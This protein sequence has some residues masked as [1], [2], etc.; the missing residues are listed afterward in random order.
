MKNHSQIKSLVVG[1]LLTGVA[2]VGIGA[3]GGDKDRTSWEYKIFIHSS[4]KIPSGVETKLTE[5]GSL[6]W[7]AV[8]FDNTTSRPWV[9]LKRP[10]K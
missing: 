9:L 4:E 3:I 6:G 5:L 1:A 2:F 7:E 10:K 8:G